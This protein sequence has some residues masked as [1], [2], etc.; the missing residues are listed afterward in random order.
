MVENLSR[1]LCLC[2]TWSRVE[3]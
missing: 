2:D 1:T 3:S